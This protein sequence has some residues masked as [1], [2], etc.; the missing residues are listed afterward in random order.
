VLIDFGTQLRQKKKKHTK[1][2][3]YGKKVSIFYNHGKEKEKTLRSEYPKREKVKT[4]RLNRY[5]V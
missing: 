4:T 5:E 1:L 3:K 2:N